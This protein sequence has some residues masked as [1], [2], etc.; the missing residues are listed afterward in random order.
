MDKIDFIN[1][2][3]N[4]K[5]API[6]K[7]L[8]KY[9]LFDDFT[10]DMLDNS[11]VYLC[12]AGKLDDLSECKVDF[13]VQDFYDLKT[14][15]LTFKGIKMILGYIRP[16][17]SE[18]NFQ[19]IESIVARTLTP[20]GSVRRHFLLDATCDIQELAPRVNISPLIN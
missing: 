9:R 13:S 18:V 1:A 15:R 4:K 10:Y 20:D 14:N 17:T 5:D 12:P 16:Y 6:P 19:L 11:Y 7:F 8:Y 2:K 3:I